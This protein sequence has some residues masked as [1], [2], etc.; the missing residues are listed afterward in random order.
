MNVTSDTSKI[1]YLTNPKYVIIYIN[2]EPCCSRYLVYRKDLHFF[3]ETGFSFDFK[4]CEKEI[5][6]DDNCNKNCK[7]RYKIN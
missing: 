2:F 7:Q 4:S 5:V 3:F 1:N 6:C